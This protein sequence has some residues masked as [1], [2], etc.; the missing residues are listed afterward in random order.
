MPNM[1]AVWLTM[2]VFSFGGMWG[3][4]DTTYIYSEELKSLPTLLSQISSSGIARAGAGAAAS[5]LMMIPPILIFILT[6]SNVI[7]SMANSGL[8]E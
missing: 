4:S 7:E 8:K 2:I 3:R 1:K 6:Q 5:V